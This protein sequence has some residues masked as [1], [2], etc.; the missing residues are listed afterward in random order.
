MRLHNILL[1]AIAIGALSSCSALYEDLD[2]CPHGVDIVTRFTL[3][4]DGV[5]KC[6]ELVHCTQLLIYGTDGKFYGVYDVEGDSKSIEL[7]VGNYRAIAYGGMSCSESSYDYSHDFSGEPHHYTELETFIKGSRAVESSTRL[8]SQFHGVTTF[9][10]SEEDMQHVLATI[11]L[12]HN[13][14]NVRVLLSYSDASQVMAS[15]FDVY[16]TADNAVMGHDNSV[17]TQGE[18]VI[19]RPYADGVIAEGATTSGAPAPNTYLDLSIGRLTAD[20]NATLHIV[21]KSDGKEIWKANLPEYFGKVL[22][23]DTKSMSLQDYLDRKYEWTMEYTLDPET[24]LLFGL[25]IKVNGW[26]II[27]NRFDL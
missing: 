20:S 27:L 18:D 4:M 23:Q 15:D 19:Y 7:P 3:N 8:H 24:D 16:I 1:S 2:P 13:T 11:D 5:D 6:E 9:T 12:T 22:E 25:T 10:V 21:R 17:K 14:N 26:I